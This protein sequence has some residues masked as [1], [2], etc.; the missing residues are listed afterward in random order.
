MNFIIWFAL[1]PGTYVDPRIVPGFFY[2]VRPAY[3]RKN[4]FGG[5][6]LLLKSIGL[7]YGKRIVFESSQLNDNINYFW[8]DSFSDGFGFSI[9]VV[10]AGMEFVIQDEDGAVI[11][12][13]HIFK[14]DAPQ[15][16][17]DHLIFSAGTVSK[18]VRVDV[19]CHIRFD[20]ENDV[21]TLRVN[22]IA[23]VKKGQ[24]DCQAY[25]SSITNIGIASQLY[26]MFMNK[27]TTLTFRPICRV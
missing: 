24:N 6:A 27:R 12:Q 3:G 17:E 8:S 10:F 9:Q 11:G 19:N 1:F 20:H 7:G 2:R 21:R 4:L 16:E 26:I 18:R 22:G 15:I 5:Q 23:V 13:A 25:V 14:A